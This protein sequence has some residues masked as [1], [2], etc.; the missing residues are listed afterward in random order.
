L[1]AQGVRQVQFL[2]IIECPPGVERSAEILCRRIREAAQEVVCE[3]SLATREIS[4]TG[5]VTDRMSSNYKA[6]VILGAEHNDLLT[7]ATL[8][9]DKPDSRPMD[10]AEVLDW[11]QSRT[12]LL[13]RY[14]V[15]E[16][17]EGTSP[18]GIRGRTIY[19]EVDDFAHTKQ[20]SYQYSPYL[21]EALMQL[22][23][24]YIVMRD[25][26]EQRSMIPYGISEMLFARKCEKGEPIVLEARMKDQTE[27]GIAWDARGVDGQGRTVMYASNLTMRW[28][29]K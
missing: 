11:Y 21:L 10:H 19:A 1:K 3:L 9:L 26:N 29:S 2:D 17:I 7:V 14:R 15:I 12:D 23:N 28:F 6:Q 13:G 27:E 16:D 18:R 25:A 22:V 4:P 5:R 24:F 20:T 8:G